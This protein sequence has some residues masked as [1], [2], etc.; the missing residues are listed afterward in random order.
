MKQNIKKTPQ[1]FYFLAIEALCMSN[2]L[3]K[4]TTPDRI[5]LISVIFHG[6]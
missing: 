5:N 3:L 4:N 6:L 1:N 2:T